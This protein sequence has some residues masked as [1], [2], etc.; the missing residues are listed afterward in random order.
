MHPKTLLKSEIFW[1]EIQAN[2]YAPKAVLKEK[3]IALSMFIRKKERLNNHELITQL[4]K[5]K[6][7]NKIKESRRQI[8]LKYGQK[9]RK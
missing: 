9:L 3:C 5:L 6:Q 8:I 2:E 1:T 7:Q 4:M